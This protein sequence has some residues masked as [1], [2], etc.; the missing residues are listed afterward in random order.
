MRDS[1]GSKNYLEKINRGAFFF[2]EEVFLEASF[3]A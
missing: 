2:L 3:R 1:C